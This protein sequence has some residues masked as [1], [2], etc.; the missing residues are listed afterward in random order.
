MDYFSLTTV[1]HEMARGIIGTL[2]TSI[3]N[4]VQVN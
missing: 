4:L 1:N 3:L 2:P